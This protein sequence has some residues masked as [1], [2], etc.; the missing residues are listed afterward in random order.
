MTGIDRGEVVQLPRDALRIA[1]PLAIYFLLRFLVSFAMGCWIR[2]DDP[3]TTAIAFTGT[4]NNFELVIAVAIAA[5]RLASPVAFATAIGPVVGV[6][7]LIVLVRVALKLGRAWCR[8]VAAPERGASVT[9]SRGR[10]TEA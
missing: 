9:R 5:F 10:V 4:S 7:V 6:L 3:R 8:G 2:A 1:V